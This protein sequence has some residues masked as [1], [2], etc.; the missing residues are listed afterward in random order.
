[1]GQSMSNVSEYEFL[2]F[3]VLAIFVLELLARRA[4]LPPAGAFILGGIA[5]ALVPGA[6]ALTIDPDLILLVFMPP[7]L[8]HGAYFTVWREFRANLTGILLLAFGAVAFTTLLVGLAAHWLVPALPWA[9]CFTLGAIV[10]PPDAVA[11]G[12]VL[13]RLALPGRISALL[14]GESLL[15]DASGLVLFRL[16]LTAALTGSFSAPAAFG[17]LCLLS[18]GGVA[19]GFVVGHAGLLVLRRLRDSELTITATLLLAVASYIVGDRLHVSGVLSTVTAGLV[20]G[21]H[22]HEIISA[23]TRVRAQAF[24]KVMVFLLE[25]ILFILIGLSLRGVLERVDTHPQA[26]R[27][28]AA[29][30]AGVVGAL[31]V[32]RFLWIFG[33]DLLHR[34]ARRFGRMRQAE[35]S[36][37]TATLLSW[38]GMRGV[39]T[40]AAALS[41]P[42]SLPGRDIVLICAFAVILVTVLLQAPTLAPLI[43]LLRVSG[44]S[45]LILRRDSEDLAWLRMAQAQHARIAALSHQPDGTER[46]PRLLEQYGHRVRVAAAYRADRDAHEPRRIDHFNAIIAAI[47]AGRLAVLRMHRAGEIDDRVLRTLEYE[48]DLQQMAAESQ[49]EDE[50]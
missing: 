13:E 35:P 47:A 5:L 6:P 9:V 44:A 4:R 2:V 27:A 49:T 1:M 26:L 46:H 39:V 16:A 34:G 31:I 18:A 22:Q 45:E 10:S 7:L 50:A 25:S 36:F 42:V 3:L 8:M 14:Q 21:W 23:A 28:L 38:A 11:A 32:S 20:L 40:L 33:T 41:L 19:V 30:V 37:A 15:N 43:R 24:W 29:P 12:A 17:A 48:L